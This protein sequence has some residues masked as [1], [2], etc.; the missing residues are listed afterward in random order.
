MKRYI[1]FV[2]ALLWILSSTSAHAELPFTTEEAETLEPGALSVDLGVGYREEPKDFG[3]EDRAHQWNLGQARVSLG[4]GSIVELQV[5]GVLAQQIETLDGDE[6]TNNGDW[7]F[8]TKV[9]LFQERKKRPAISFLYQVKMPNG[10]NEKGGSTDE[11][12]FFGYLVLS[13]Q[14]APGQVL[15]ANLGIGILGNPDAMASQDDIAI[16]RLAWERQISERT[17]IGLEGF[18]QTG[19]KEKDDPH[20]LQVVA[21]HHLQKWAVYAGLAVGLGDDADQ[22]RASI[23][24]RYR[25]SLWSPDRSLV[26]RNAW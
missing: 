22:L 1:Q 10:A 6:T 24:A 25:F 7:V 5:S 18:F 20:Y 26:R 8:G 13:K 3:V 19:P 14:I 4:L 9:W 17:I 2:L 15:H 12:D 21:A 16:L 11:T 23:G